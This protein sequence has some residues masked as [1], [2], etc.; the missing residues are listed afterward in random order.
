MNYLKTLKFGSNKLKS[1]NIDSHI[2]DSELLLSFVLK[3]P[4]EHILV[5]LNE[6]IKKKELKKFKQLLSRREKKNQ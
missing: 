4:R 2:L 6:N 1:N 5:N 3:S